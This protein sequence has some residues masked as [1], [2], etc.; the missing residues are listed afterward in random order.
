MWGDQPEWPGLIV[1]WRAIHR[2]GD[3]HIGI[4]E[5]RVQLG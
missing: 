2:V 1:K 5:V 3:D 4:L